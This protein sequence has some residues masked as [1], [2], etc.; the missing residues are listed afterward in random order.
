MNALKTSLSLKL[1]V[2]LVSDTVVMG[3]A[4]YWNGEIDLLKTLANGDLAGQAELGYLAERQIA[5]GGND[6]ID[7]QSALSDVFGDA[8]TFAKLKV[9]FVLNRP[10]LA[11]GTPNTTNL[12]IGGGS[13]PF[14]G[15]ASG[16]I[17]PIRPGGLVM[18]AA[19]HVD[20]IGSPIAGT[21]DILRIANSA[22]ATNNYVLGL[23][24]V[25]A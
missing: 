19:D 23:I 22:G 7:L 15:I 12:T 25:A 6:D 13:N 3:Q 16:T 11:D 1:A 20:G 21:G 2:N 17:G 8:L 24:G 10:R 18:I 9:L 4:Q 5:S 14:V